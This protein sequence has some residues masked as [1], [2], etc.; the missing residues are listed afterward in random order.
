MVFYSLCGW[1]LLSDLCST[2]NR[3]F[4]PP[5]PAN[6]PTCKAGSLPHDLDLLIIGGSSDDHQHK[7]SITVSTSRT[8][9]SLSL[10]R[11]TLSAAPFL[12]W[13]TS[14]QEVYLD[15]NNFTSIPAGYFTGLSSLQILSMSQNINLYIWVF[16][17]ELTEASS[18]V[19]FAAGNVNLYGSLPDVF[20]L[21]PNLQNL[22]LSYNN[23]TGLRESFV[24]NIH[25]NEGK[26]DLCGSA[27]LPVS[28]ASAETLD[29]GASRHLGKAQGKY[30]NQGKRLQ[31]FS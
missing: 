16:P 22:R 4:C 13:P 29:S 17:S 8:H 15:T 7:A 18:L 20:D 23:F 30:F 27:D 19:T 2:S 12:L 25:T 10:S 1:F 28:A 31:V 21:F 9:H 5:R 14:L 11:A 26:A 24:Q 3:H 6:R